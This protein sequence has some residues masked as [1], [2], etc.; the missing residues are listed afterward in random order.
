MNILTPNPSPKER[1]MFIIGRLGIDFVTIFGQKY[2]PKSFGGLVVL[3]I[4]GLHRGLHMWH[5]YGVRSG[6]FCFYGFQ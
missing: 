5:T 2:A 1:G 4:S 3:F 6:F